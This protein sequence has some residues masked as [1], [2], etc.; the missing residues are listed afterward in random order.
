MQVTCSTL[1]LELSTVNLGDIWKERVKMSSQQY[2]DELECL[3]VG[4][5]ASILM[6][7]TLI[8]SSKSPE[9][10][11][12]PSVILSM[13]LLMCKFFAL[14]VSPFLGRGSLSGL[15]RLPRGG[16]STLSTLSS[17]NLSSNRSS[18]SLPE[19]TKAFHVI[20]VC[21]LLHS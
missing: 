14:S 9:C 20:Y 15:S 3:D 13:C 12:L 19:I 16:R 2:R 18:L 7:K 1:Y 6:E 21:Y 11:C 5:L 10:L 8:N 4:W 17:L